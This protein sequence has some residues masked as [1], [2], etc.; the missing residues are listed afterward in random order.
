MPISLASCCCAKL[1]ISN[2]P[3]PVPFPFLH[4][5]RLSL[6]NIQIEFRALVECVSSRISIAFHVLVKY[7]RTSVCVSVWVQVNMSVS[8]TV[9]VQSSVTAMSNCLS[10]KTKKRPNC[11]MIRPADILSPECAHEYAVNIHL[12]LATH[13]NATLSRTL[14]LTLHS[15]QYAN[16]APSRC[17]FGLDLNAFCT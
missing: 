11:V 9:A 6:G 12:A 2:P 5:L 7:L 8:V 14:R 3:L 16:C 13:S 17:P 1:F 10:C 15:S 4:T